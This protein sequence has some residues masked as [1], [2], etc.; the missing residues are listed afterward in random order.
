LTEDEVVGAENLSV[1]TSA[2]GVHGSGLEIHEDG[3]GDVAAA[4]GLVEVNVNALQ[5]EIGVALVGSGG[6]YAMFSKIPLHW[7]R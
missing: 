6:I 3:T 5:L 7:G 4:S 2:D 1:G